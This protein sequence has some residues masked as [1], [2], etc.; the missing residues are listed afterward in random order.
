MPSAKTKA[1]SMPASP[2]IMKPTARNNAVIAASRMAVR[3]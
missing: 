1:K 3:R 2:P